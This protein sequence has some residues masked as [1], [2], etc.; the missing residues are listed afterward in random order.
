MERFGKGY[1]VR[2]LPLMCKF[3]L[4]FAPTI[5]KSHFSQLE[6]EGI[7]TTGLLPLPF[8]LSWSYCLL[9]CRLEPPDERQLYEAEAGTK[10]MVHKR[11]P[12]ANGFG[13]HAWP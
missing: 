13:P 3:F 4:L 7:E 5:A 8:R 12:A 2:Y 1:S 10:R 9:L 11:P 6:L